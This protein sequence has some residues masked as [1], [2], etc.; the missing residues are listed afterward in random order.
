MLK[1]LLLLSP[2][3]A[4]AASWFSLPYIPAAPTWER[5]LSTDSRLSVLVSFFGKQLESFSLGIISYYLIYHQTKT[6][7]VLASDDDLRRNPKAR[8]ALPASWLLW[9]TRYTV[10]HKPGIPL[11]TS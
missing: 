9:R 2:A 8:R 10:P 6:F 11:R 7:N 4:R 3:P 5:P 1:D